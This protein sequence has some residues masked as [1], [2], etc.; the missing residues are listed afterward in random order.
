MRPNEDIKAI[1]D[2][3]TI[4][5]TRLKSYGKTYPHGEVMR[6]MLQSLSKSWEA[7]K[8]GSRKQKLKAHVAT[9]SDDDSPD[10]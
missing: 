2:R 3:F 10:N 4:I 6:K 8:N 5:I 1:S 9:W 7:K